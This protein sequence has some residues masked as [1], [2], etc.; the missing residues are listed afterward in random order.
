MK[1]KKDFTG[2]DGSTPL[3]NQRHE[4]FCILIV[5]GKNTGDAYVAAGFKEKDAVK[6][7]CA[8]MKRPE[9]LERINFLRQPAIEKAQLTLETH[10]KDL[11]D[12][13]DAALRNGEF[14][15][16]VAAE[17]ARGKA[18]GLYVTKTEAKVGVTG[19]PEGAD[20]EFRVTVRKAASA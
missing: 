2:Y 17:V 13:R 3:E 14:S 11:Q 7:A 20:F 8:L 4:R 5:E 18:A 12:I 19:I 15:P 6:T 10:L 16:A 9:I 1:T